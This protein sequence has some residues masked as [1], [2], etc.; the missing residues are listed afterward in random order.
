MDVASQDDDASKQAGYDLSSSAW[1]RAP[2]QARSE[3]TLNRFLDATIELLKLRPFSEVSVND[4]VERAGRTV[5]SFYARF[6][7]KTGVLRVLVERTAADL[8]DEASAYWVPDNFVDESLEEIVGRT[9]DAVLGAYRDAE[10]VFHAAA[11]H[12]PLDVAFRQARQAVWIACAEGWGRVLESNRHIIGCDDPH[13]AG[14][15]TMMA[16]ISI[17]DVRLLYGSE[18]RPLYEDESELR[19]DLIAMMMASLRP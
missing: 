4:I 1:V 6:D 17:V 10:A 19:D 15:F 12:A 3:E 7:D 11:V 5:G 14:Q 9:V 13:R 16:V 18:T 2:R 8:R